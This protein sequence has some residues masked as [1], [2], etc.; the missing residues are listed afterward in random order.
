MSV[1]QTRETCILYSNFGY[2]Y[3]MYLPFLSKRTNQY[4]IGHWTV[5]TSS[6]IGN[7]M[8]VTET[9]APKVPIKPSTQFHLI[10]VRWTQS[11]RT[12]D[13]NEM[14]LEKLR[15]SWRF[16]VFPAPTVATLNS[17][18]TDRSLIILIFKQNGI[19]LDVFTVV[20]VC[21]C[22]WWFI[23]VS[24][25]RIFTIH[26]QDMDGAVNGLTSQKRDT[27]VANEIENDVI[28]W[29]ATSSLVARCS[30]RTMYVFHLS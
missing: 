5:V 24:R 27:S 20:C 14:N 2:T 1:L 8:C 16:T 4:H 30:R 13:S 18:V 6:Y 9:G 19:K 28:Y 25:L 22:G 12:R 17:C 29:P 23:V 3:S 15:L 11:A 26:M 7:S 10:Q 21:V